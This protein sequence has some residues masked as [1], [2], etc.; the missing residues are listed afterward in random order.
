MRAL[1]IG[2][3][4]ASLA[5]SSCGAIILTAPAPE[6]YTVRQEQQLALQRQLAVLQ[7]AD[8]PELR[9]PHV[10]LHTIPRSVYAGELFTL[11]FEITADDAPQLLVQRALPPLHLQVSQEPADGYAGRITLGPWLLADPAP[12][13]PGE[14]DEALD[15][16]ELSLRLSR[17]GTYV[18]A[19]QSADKP[20]HGGRPA[21]YRQDGTE[22]IRGEVAISTTEV[23]LNVLPARQQPVAPR[24]YNEPYGAYRSSEAT[25]DYGNWRGGWQQPQEHRHWDW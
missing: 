11:R 2:T 25:W 12:L 17:P 9:L 23:Y 22:F 21:R 5:L 13:L 24:F 1:L 6:P 3:V 15:S 19:L 20:E 7:Q 10:V 18:L 4:A 8:S 14:F 16:V